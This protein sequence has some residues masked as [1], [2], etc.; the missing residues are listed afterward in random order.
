[1]AI[2]QR[3]SAQTASIAAPIGGWNAR[4]SVAEMNPLDAVVLQN[5]FP[6]PSDIVLRKGYSV[7][8]SSI[9][10]QVNS[11]MNYAGPTEQK[12]FAAAGSR[13][14]NATSSTAVEELTGLAN[15]KFQYVNISTAG[16]NFLVACNGA[17][18]VLVYNGT[19]WFKIATT[20]TGVTVSTDTNVGAVATITTTAAHGLVTGNQVTVSGA[21]GVDANLYNGTFIITVTGANTFSYTMTGTPTASATG[22]IAYIPTGITGADSSTFVNVNLYKN[23][24]WFVQE[25]TMKVYYLPVNSIAGASSAIDFGGIAR[26]GGYLQAMGTWTIDAGEGVD[27]Y[28]AFVTSMGE[29]IVYTGTDPTSPSTWALK[30]VWQLGQTYTRRCFLKWSGDLL[31]LTQ[32]GLVPM[33]SALQSSRLDPRVNLTDKIFYAIAQAADLYQTNFGWQIAYYAKQNMLIINVP[34]NDGP[35]QFVMHTITKAWAN[36]TDIGAKCFEIHNDDMY[37]GGDGF[38]GKFWDT[39]ADNE[40]NIVASVQQAYS[41]FDSRGQQKRFTMVRPILQ[42]DNGTPTISCGI[43]VDFDTTNVAGSV[44]FSPATL[45][46]GVWDTSVWDDAIWSGGL[47]VN[48]VWQ[49]VSG[50]GYAAGMFMNIASQ[51]INVRWASTDYVMERGGV[52]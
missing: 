23:R 11:L 10:T 18:P 24:L 5:W 22:T 44:T 29:V 46:V 28:A 6:T 14:Y 45:G 47:V 3:R 4:D 33:A 35:Q 2:A 19:Y 26:N 37:F 38:V 16:G 51:D 43:N 32:D 12:L 25:D 50:I 8:S 31:L 17:D 42:V 15:D 52:I 30:G 49:G 1:M 48:K 7:H 39:N 40:T 9:S 27:D 34:A 21:T 13:I 41:Y 36:F 20:S